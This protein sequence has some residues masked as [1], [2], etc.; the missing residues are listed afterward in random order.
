M[1][2]T[3]SFVLTS[4]LRIT[5]PSSPLDELLPK[6]G[7]LLKRRCFKILHNES[8]V[9]DAMQEILLVMHRSYDQYRGDPEKILGWLYRI[10]TTHCLRLLEKHKRWSAVTQRWLEEHPD[11]L[12][13][14]A[15]TRPS[16]SAEDVL[17]L[18]QVLETLGEEEKS[19]AIYKYVDGMTQNE[20]AEVMGITRERV[21]H[22]LGLFQKHGLLLFE[23]E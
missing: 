19:I 9:E 1:I 20:I 14:S 22:R 4:F 8:L 3:L 21:R 7:Y 5:K 12:S 16:V 18:E 17:T 23:S 15:Q 10:A 2:A 11:G 13:A 6:Y